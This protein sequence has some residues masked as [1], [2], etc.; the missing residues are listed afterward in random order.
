[1]RYFNVHLQDRWYIDLIEK[2][3]LTKTLRSNPCCNLWQRFS[4]T[5]IFLI[6]NQNSEKLQNL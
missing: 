1:M 4:N 2:Y 6:L 3:G 5:K